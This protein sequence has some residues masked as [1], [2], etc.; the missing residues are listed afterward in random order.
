VAADRVQFLGGNGNGS[1]RAG[2]EPDYEDSSEIP[3]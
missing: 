2:E 3:F 1:G